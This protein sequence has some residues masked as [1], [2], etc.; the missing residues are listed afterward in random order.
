MPDYNYRFKYEC[1]AD[2]KFIIENEEVIIPAS[3]IKNYYLY[4]ECYFKENKTI[5]PFPGKVYVSEDGD[6]CNGLDCSIQV[7]SLLLDESGNP[8]AYEQDD[9]GDE[10]AAGFIY[11]GKLYFVHDLEEV[12]Y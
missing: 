1:M 10:Q 5:L 12:T 2:R 6:F 7:P 9:N 11:E 8:L 4:P 3:Q